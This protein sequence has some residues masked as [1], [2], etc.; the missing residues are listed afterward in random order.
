MI[1]HCGFNQ[2]VNG[3]TRALRMLCKIEMTE[4]GGW[5]IVTPYFGST[6]K[7]YA[8]CCAI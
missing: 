5:C 1:V 7:V 4:D 3:S 8:G 2:R 6:E